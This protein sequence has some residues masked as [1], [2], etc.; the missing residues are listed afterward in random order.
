MK[1]KRLLEEIEKMEGFIDWQKTEL[2]I[3]KINSYNDAEV[4]AD[5][6][7]RISSVREVE[8]QNKML[9]KDSENNAV[10]I[11]SLTKKVSA[12]REENN[13]LIKSNQVLLEK[14]M[15][16]VGRQ[17]IDPPKK[18]RWFYLWLM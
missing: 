15:K 7:K 2:E 12:L 9:A 6:R 13:A 8:E 3:S 11:A 18:R 17:Y 16:L 1:K 4:I 5:L 14:N 10:I